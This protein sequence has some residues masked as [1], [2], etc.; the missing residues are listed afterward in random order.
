MLSAPGTSRNGSFVPWEEATVTRSTPIASAGFARRPDRPKCDTSDARP[1]SRD[2]Q[3]IATWAKSDQDRFGAQAVDGG[4]NRETRMTSSSSIWPIVL[5]GG[6][7]RRMQSF[8]RSWLGEERPKQYCEF[9]GR[10]SMLGH[11][12]D[13]ARAMAPP[14]QVTTIVGRGHLQ[15]LAGIEE[16]APGTVIE[17]PADRGTAPGIFLP[18]ALVAARDPSAT[19]VVMPSDHFIHPKA[20]F[21]ALAQ[22]A[23]REAAEQPGKLVM[24]GARPLWPETDFGWIL[25]AAA[26]HALPLRPVAGFE[27][28]PDRERAER[29]LAVGGL[30]NTMI[31]AAR[32]DTLW[33][34]GQRLLPQM[35]LPLDALRRELRDLPEERSRAEID[36]AISRAYHRMPHA[37]FSRDLVQRCPGAALVLSLGSIEW[38]DWGRPERV[39]ESL[40]RLG[41]KPA[42][43]T[44]EA[45]P[46]LGGV[47]ISAPPGQPSVASVV[48]AVQL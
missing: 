29:F 28:K 17:Q 31:V 25:P 19:V 40:R 24:L 43:P 32:V 5:A 4:P 47:L 35:M 23:C 9:S 18:T 34:L 16:P 37:D 7:G 11:T 3:I 6:E 13:R 41:K 36:R 15:F 45:S 46:I 1:C 48:S 21:I 22:A 38:S 14:D 33:R 8:I 30:W 2:K 42:F 12:W 27:E 39:A 44:R 10:R 26:Q 20:D